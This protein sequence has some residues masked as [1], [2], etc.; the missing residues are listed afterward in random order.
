MAGTITLSN[1]IQPKR[2]GILGSMRFAWT[3][4]TGGAVNGTTW[5]FNGR[6]ERLVT[7]PGAAAPTANY[8]VTVVDEDGVDLL[9]GVGA[10]RHT[11]TSEQAAPVLGTYFQP[12]HAGT[13]EPKVANAGASKT[14]EIILYYSR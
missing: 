10:D 5:V 4:D 7:N 14:G 8:D 11:S 9:G 13:I 2:N 12:A 3:S 6:L 1:H